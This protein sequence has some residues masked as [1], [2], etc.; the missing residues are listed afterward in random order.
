MAY[1]RIRVMLEHPETR[2]FDLEVRNADGSSRWEHWI[3][4]PIVDENGKVVEI[5]GIA[6]DVTELKHAEREARIQ[7]ERIT[8]LTRVAILGEFS[9]ALAHELNQPLTAMMS[10]AQAAQILLA[11]NEPDI[12]ELAE[13]MDDIVANNRRARDVI[14]GLRKLLRGRTPEPTMIDVNDLVRSVLTLIRSVMIDRNIVVSTDLAGDLPAIRG[15]E[16]QLQQVLLNLIMNACDAIGANDASNRHVWLVTERDSDRCIRLAVRDNG[17]GID[18]AIHERLFEPYFTTKEE[19]LGLGLSICR[20]IIESHGGL[21]TFDDDHVPG[22]CFEFVL[23]IRAETE[24]GAT[25][26]ERPRIV[27]ARH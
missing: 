25:T 3:E 5:Q 10:D 23:P 18:E 24:R 27:A 4:H 8:H 15:D 16:V 26:I 21:L 22:A 14:A 7:R 11:Q 20:S 17:P 13:I 6:R 9:G 12:S 2:T 19:G 1:E